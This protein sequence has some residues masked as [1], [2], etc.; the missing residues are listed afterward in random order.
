M[1]NKELPVGTVLKNGQYKIISV[2]GSG[3]FGIT[4]K[5]DCGPLKRPHFTAKAIK[6]A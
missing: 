3:G 2:L 5:T 6:Y 1:E 4:Y